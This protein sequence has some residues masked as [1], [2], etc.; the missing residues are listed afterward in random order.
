MVGQPWV[1]RGT[2][3]EKL[4]G[5][6]H[7]MPIPVHPGDAGG[8]VGLHQHKEHQEKASTLSLLGVGTFPQDLRLIWVKSRGSEMGRRDGGSTA[9]SRICLAKVQEHLSTL[10]AQD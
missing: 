6:G 3:E 8:W 1:A 2:Q 9:G 5:V 7:H 4:G 10:F